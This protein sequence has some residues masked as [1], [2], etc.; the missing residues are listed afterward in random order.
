MG[1]L[2]ELQVMLAQLLD[3]CF[4]GKL[5]VVASGSHFN[6]VVYHCSNKDMFEVFSH[7]LSNV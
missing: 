3:V 4:Q 5:V 7:V 6:I 2:V 1:Q